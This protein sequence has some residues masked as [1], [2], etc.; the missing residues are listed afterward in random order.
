M[1]ESR[2]ESYKAAGVDVPAGFDAVKLM[3]PLVEST[4]T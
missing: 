3:K 4:F 1:T 2:S